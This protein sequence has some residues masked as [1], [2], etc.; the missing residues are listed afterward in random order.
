LSERAD[1]ANTTH[2][3]IIVHCSA[4]IGRSGTFCTVH[5]T[6]QQLRLNL[7]ENPSK[8]PEFNIVKTILDER[9]QRPGMVQTKEQY[10]FC[11]L[12][13][14]EEAEKLLKQPI[15]P[16]SYFITNLNNTS[17]LNT[18]AYQSSFLTESSNLR[19][20]WEI[21]TNNNV[22]GMLHQY[23]LDD[24]QILMM[25]DSSIATDPGEEQWDNM[26]QYAESL[27]Q[28]MDNMQFQSTEEK[29]FMDDNN[30]IQP[31]NS[32]TSPYV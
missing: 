19:T 15:T 3:P 1:S 32:E 21:P 29:Q 12:A 17:E 31:E 25:P 6:I 26:H 9:K 28:Y 2:A 4:G 8:E 10:M 23:V 24:T 14:L 11:Y 7:K 30:A 16:I 20:S 18:N 13:I 5:S 22:G 27:K